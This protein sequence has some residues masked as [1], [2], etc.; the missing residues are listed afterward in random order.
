MTILFKEALGYAA[1]S[2]CALLVDM[3]LLWA[4]CII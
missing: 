3:V 2:A 4:H 1:A